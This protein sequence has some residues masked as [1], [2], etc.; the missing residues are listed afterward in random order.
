L[1]IQ[2]NKAAIIIDSASCGANNITKSMQISDNSAATA[3]YGN[4]IVGNIQV[5]SNSAPAVI[6]ANTV[7]GNIQVQ[8]NSSSNAI[9]ANRVKGSL[10]CSGNNISMLTGGGNT[11]AQ[12]QGECAGF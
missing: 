3:L 2:K 12:K 9:F 1:Q 5:N 10:Q 6:D 4:S 7:S 11:A 8:N